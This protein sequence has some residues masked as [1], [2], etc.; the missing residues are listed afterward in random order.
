[1][2]YEKIKIPAIVIL[3]LPLFF[4]CKN[5]SDTVPHFSPQDIG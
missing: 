2:I 5:N 1:M 4:S 3:V